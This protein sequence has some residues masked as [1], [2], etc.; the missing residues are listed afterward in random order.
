MPGSMGIRSYIVARK[1]SAASYHSCS[2]GAGRRMSSRQAKR[3]LSVESLQDLMAGKT[4]N[5]DKANTLLDEHP[6]SCKDIDQVMAD[7]ADLVSA[8][9]TL[10]HVFNYKGV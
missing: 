7:Q 6:A 5:A 10:R 8:Q 3:E 2:H 4:W 1:G 9:H